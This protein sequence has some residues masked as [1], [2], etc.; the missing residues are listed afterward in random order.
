M[1]IRGRITVRVFE[2]GGEV[3]R[4]NP[5]MIRSLLGL[6]GRQMKVINHNVV[7]SQGDAILADMVSGQDTKDPVDSMNGH[8]ELGT[9]WT[10]NSPK[11]N[12]GCNTPSG[13]RTALDA[14]YPVTKGFFGES[15]DNVVV[16]RVT[17]A[18]G[19]LNQSGINEAA[20]LNAS[21]G[22]EALA[23]AQ[24]SP[25]VNV[26]LNDTLQIEWEITFLGS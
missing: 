20:L 26:T 12:T 4:F 25:E 5:G 3:K 2:R 18:A 14:G 21:E 22:G 23:Y 7:T 11:S 24:V 8:I 13:T 17:Y 16:Y 15:G 6:N 19:S 10:G 1:R 9:G